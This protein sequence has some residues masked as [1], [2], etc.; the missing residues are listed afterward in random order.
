MRRKTE[1]DRRKYK[2]G[3]S[4]VSRDVLMVLEGCYRHKYR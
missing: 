4:E 2:Y 1:G 3:T